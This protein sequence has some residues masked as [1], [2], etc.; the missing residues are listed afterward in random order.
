MRKYTAGD[1]TSGKMDIGKTGP[2]IVAGHPQEHNLELGCWSAMR[3][4][5]FDH[6]FDQFIEQVK[7]K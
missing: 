5:L 4:Y 1:I 2:C 3:H 7:R 6:S